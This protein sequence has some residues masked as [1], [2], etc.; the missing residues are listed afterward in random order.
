MAMFFGCFFFP[1]VDGCV[2]MGRSVLLYELHRVHVVASGE[3]Q[4]EI[5]VMETENFETPAQLKNIFK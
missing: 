2:V 3:K 1:G 5:L 4:E